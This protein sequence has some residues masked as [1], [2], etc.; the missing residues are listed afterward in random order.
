MARIKQRQVFYIH[1]FDPRGAGH[2]HRLYRSQS[3][4]QAKVNGLHIDVS[5]RK[6]GENHSHCW[7]LDTEHCQT[8]Y[9]YLGWDDIVRAHWARGWLQI[10]G[11]LSLFLWV[12]ILPGHI[13]SYAKASPKQLMAGLYPAFYLLLSLLL[14]VWLATSLA[15]QLPW[16]MAQLPAGLVLVAALMH[17]SKHL[18]N[19]LA[20]F[21]LLRIY[22]FSAR[23]ARGQIPELAPRIH[24]FASHMA[25][26]INDDTND[27]V[28]IVAH[29]VGTMM[30][31]PALAQALQQIHNPNRL[32]HQRVVLITLGHCIPL[33]SFHA[34]AADFRTA[35]QQL[36]HNK[37]LLWLDYTA[38]TDGACF[39][40]LNPVTSCGQSCAPH[41]GPRLLSPRFFT[42][43]HPARYKKLRR[44]WYTMHF[45]YLM[46]TDKPGPYDFFAFTAGPETIA[47]QL[48]ERT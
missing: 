12:Y 13:L 39:P 16:Q 7:Q 29:S 46:A 4:L 9:S 24:S 11:D 31:V 14:S 26:A 5:A 2:Y 38:P 28:V 17:T 22:A 8:R 27:E 15:G 10:I 25:E 23:W 20:V 37:R 47:S 41:A 42:L 40:L 33:V 43:Y 6:R 3:A 18:G 30:V 32:A 34:A 44:A 19:K 35:L 1:G 21:W 48:K 36:G 45:L